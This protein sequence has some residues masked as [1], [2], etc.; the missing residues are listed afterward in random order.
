MTVLDNKKLQKQIYIK[1]LK[2]CNDFHPLL[3]LYG[4]TL[5]NTPSAGLRLSLTVSIQQLIHFWPDPDTDFWPL[6]ELDY[7][8]NN[9]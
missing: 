8:N 7:H 6:P 1:Y 2:W 4:V 3:F 9:N 5:Q